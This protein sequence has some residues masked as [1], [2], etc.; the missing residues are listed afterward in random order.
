MGQTGLKRCMNLERLVSSASAEPL[1]RGR[2]LS[3][4]KRVLAHKHTSIHPA[5]AQTNEGAVEDSELK[6]ILEDAA[7]KGIYFTIVGIGLE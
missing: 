1:V 3:P 2:P 7:A 5:D 4:N 6:S